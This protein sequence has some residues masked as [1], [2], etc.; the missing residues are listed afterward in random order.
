VLA[1][2]IGQRNLF[3]PPSLEAAA[4]YVEGEL[5][6]PG[7][8]VARQSYPV[9]GVTCH[10]LEAELRGAERPEQIVLVGAHYDTVVGSPGADDNASG[11]AGLLELARALAQVPRRR[12]LRFVAF[13]NEEPPHHHAGTM[14]SQAYARR[15]RRRGEAVVAMICLESIGFYADGRGSQRYPWPLQLLYPGTGDFIAFVSNLASRKLLRRAA[16]RFRRHASIPLVAAAL[17]AWVTGV[18]WSDHWSFWGYRA[19][20]VTDTALY[21]NPAYHTPADTARRLDYERTART[22]AGLEQVVGALA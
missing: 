7:L 12:S 21:R 11:V 16:R 1:G 2:E 18:G 5:A 14:G 4:D 3:H 17:P 13:V 19:L 9:A 8:A 15:C 22:V 6:A 10:N 20:M